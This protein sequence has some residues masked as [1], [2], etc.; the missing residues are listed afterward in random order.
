[1]IENREHNVA[2]P[3]APDTTAHDQTDEN[4]IRLVV[5]DDHGLYRASLA[6]LLASEGGFAVVGECSTPAEALEMLQGSPVDV[7]LLDF[8]V[9]PG[10]ANDFISAAQKAGYHGRFL[11]V[12]G[13]PNA[14]CSAMA[15]KLG[16][17]GIFLKSEAPERLVQAIRVIATGAVW[18]D[19]R[20]IQLLAD[21]CLNQPQ[22]TDQT[23]G[24]ALEDRQQKV[25][26]GILG[27]L[28]NRRIADGMGVS[29]GS[30]KNILQS[31]FTRT[32]VRTRSQ[33]VRMALDGSLG[34]VRPLVNRQAQAHGDETPVASP[35]KIAGYYPSVEAIIRLIIGLAARRSLIQGVSVLFE[36]NPNE[37]AS[38]ADTGFREQLLH[39]ILHG[40]LRDGHLGRDLFVCQPLD[41]QPQD[42]Y[43]SVVK[44]LH[45]PEV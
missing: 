11:I 27:G 19:R 29:E 8:D 4:R 12:A 45:V 26:L 24:G 6:R 14:Q 22:R 39:C 23:S 42:A 10:N 21:Q 41:K 25:L 37:L 18:I 43:L 15:L 7:V 44:L 34:N 1:M 17:S 20:I 38:R 28:T 13:A 35:G 40:T 31:L 30:I 5:L 36:R 9:G 3:A 2:R 32:G 16:A 33:L